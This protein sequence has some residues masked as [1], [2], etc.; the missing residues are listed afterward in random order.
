[1]CNFSN[2]IIWEITLQSS[3]II[4]GINFVP[5]FSPSSSTHLL[6]PSNSYPWFPMVVSLFLTHLPLEMTSPI[7][8]PPSP[9]RCLWSSRSKGLHWWR[10]KAYKLYMESYYFYLFVSCTM[11]VSYICHVVSPSS[12]VVRLVCTEPIYSCYH[13]IECIWIIIST[14]LLSF[15]GGS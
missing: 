8:F 6:L 1:M 13:V 14:F 11:H 3:Y 2:S 4:W 15:L 7:T 5:P 9:L 10:Y 12:V